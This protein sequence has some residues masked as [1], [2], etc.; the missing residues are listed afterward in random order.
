[1]NLRRDYHQKRYLHLDKDQHRA[2]SREWARRHTTGQHQGASIHKRP[3]PQVCELCGEKRSKRLEYHHWDNPS[4]GVWVCDY[5][6]K[7]VEL[8][9]KGVDIKD[10][11][12]KYREL[13][14]IV[15]KEWAT[16]L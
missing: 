14:E 2:R 7:V 3:R 4:V 12:G 10:I 5:C 13:K 16:L 15:E 11:A 8:I 1:M 9:D 6:H